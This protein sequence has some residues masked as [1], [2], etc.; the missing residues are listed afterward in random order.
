[1]TLHLIR[2]IRVLQ[3]G[4]YHNN[5]SNFINETKQHYDASLDKHKEVVLGHTT[6]FFWVSMVVIQ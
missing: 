6:T 4:T 2:V 3:K 1:M 5:C